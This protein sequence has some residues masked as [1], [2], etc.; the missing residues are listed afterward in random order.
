MF[1]EYM[2]QQT[3]TKL[4]GTVIE[5]NIPAGATINVGNLLELTSP[6]GICLNVRI[7]LLAGS[8]NLGGI[9]ESLKKAGVTVEAVNQ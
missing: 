3:C 1:E 9:V 8:I 7:P 2:P 5:I 6:S 4:P